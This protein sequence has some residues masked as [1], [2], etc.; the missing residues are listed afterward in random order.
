MHLSGRFQLMQSHLVGVAPTSAAASERAGELLSELDE[1]FEV[2]PSPDG[3][4]HDGFALIEIGG[5][6]ADLEEARREVVA[7]LEQIDPRWGESLKV[8]EAPQG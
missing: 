1:W 5:H 3:G 7:R 4:P 8:L 6:T 2:S